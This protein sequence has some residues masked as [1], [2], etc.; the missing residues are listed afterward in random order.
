M[1]R[2]ADRTEAGRELATMLQSF[3]GLPDV[4][5]LGLPR[6]G[7]PV[8]F[9]VATALDLPLDVF[10]VRKLG[11]PG[12]EEF[13]IGA[14][15]T[16]GITTIDWATAD[17]MRV[18]DLTIESVVAREREE[19]AR[20]ERLYRGDAPLPPLAGRTVIVVDDG[21]ATG[22]TMYAAVLALRTVKPARIIVAAPVASAEARELLRE[23]ADACVCV[24]VPGRLYSVGQWYENFTPTTD[25]EVLHLLSRETRRPR[26]PRFAPSAST[27]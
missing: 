3:A 23:V 16:G 10:T 7:V 17:A 13:A 22:W 14:I 11:L 6:G 18:T 12:N 21:L 15:A 26:A 4:I 20:R 1:R 27:A 2:F 9:E 24:Y 5:V 8:A 25:A 19:L